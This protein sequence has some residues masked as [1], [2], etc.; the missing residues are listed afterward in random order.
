VGSNILIK[1]ASVIIEHFI[2]L[3]ILKLGRSRA[4]H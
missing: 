4:K 3:L 1:A 2:M